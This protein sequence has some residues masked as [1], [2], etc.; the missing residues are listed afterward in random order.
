MGKSPPN[1]NRSTIALAILP[2]TLLVGSWHLTPHSML[3]QAPIDRKAQAD[4]FQQSCQ[5][6]TQRQQYL[7]AVIE[8]Q[9]AVTAFRELGDR[10]R[11]AD[12]LY[13][14]GIVYE[15]VSRSWDA[16]ASYKQ[17]LSIDET[18]SNR[19]GQANALLGLGNTYRSRAQYEWAM[20]YYQQAHSLYVSSNN[21]IGQ[22]H[23]LLGLGAVYQAQSNYQIALNYY[24]DALS[25]FY[26]TNDR[27]GQARA[28]LHLG[29]FY[30]VLSQNQ[31]AIDYYKDALPIFLSLQDRRGEAESLIS[32]GNAY[33]ADHHPQR[34]M[35]YY[36]QALPLFL[37]IDDPQGEAT[38]LLRFGNAHHALGDYQPALEAYKKALRLFR[39]LD[40][41]H[42]EADV[43]NSLGLT[44]R[45]L[46]Q[47]PLAI[48]HFKQAIALYERVGDRNGKAI[49]LGNLGE[50][51][52][53]TGELEAAK[54]Y[55]QQSI[56]LLESIRGN[57]KADRDR[58]S[59]FEIQQ[60]PYVNLQKV[61]V[62][63]EK[64]LPAL[65]I[66][67]RGRARA[68]VELLA[69]K[70]DESSPSEARRLS[71]P[72][73]ATPITIRQIQ[74][75]A[76]E[77]NAHLVEYSII[78]N[79]S[80]YIWVVKPSGD[81]V[82]QQVNLMKLP[83][84]T[85]NPFQTLLAQLRTDELELR[86][87]SRSFETDLTTDA[88]TSASSEFDPQDQSNLNQLHQILIAPIAQHLPK[89][90]KQRIVFIPQRELFFVP[91]PALKDGR[92]TYL[93]ANHTLTTAPSIQ[94]LQLTRQ[95]RRR[96]GGRGNPL[97]VGNP[98][99]PKIGNP[100]EPLSDLP[101]AEAE[102]RAIAQLFGVNFLSGSQATKS[103]VVERMRFAPLIHF[104][105]HGLLDDY[106]GLGIPGAI[107]L[108]PENT[109]G[110]DGLGKINGM[111]TASEILNLSLRAELVVVSACDTGRGRITGDGVI[112]L[113]RAFIAAGA[114]SVVVSLWK[115]PDESTNFLMQQFYQNLHQKMNKAQAL[116]QAMLTTQQKFPDPQ[117]WAAF[118]LIGEAE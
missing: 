52:L 25:R 84:Y 43:L 27:W 8:C 12:A 99:M 26:A 47:Y 85:S 96:E 106:R 79:E 23:A 19:S 90:P 109:P 21:L 55:L 88:Q 68:F 73:P 60:D 70:I 62:A 4:Q 71:I 87:R 111:L 103:R 108:A 11:E 76:R 95:Q 18:L 65:E 77:Q 17:A 3:A 48:D 46:A 75:I 40:N 42:R 83:R 54:N 41:D 80:L 93:T 50:T 39:G 28:L 104:A 56:E 36:K 112:G 63:Q 101:G 2:I 14:V 94:V 105:T 32:L 44:H 30:H 69:H 45:Q 33:A 118:T 9:N 31:R 78:G 57:L 74:Q 113:S 10:A 59:I 102:A 107:A 116:Q 67:E 37:S 35:N 22:S 110:R 98:T 7:A 58:V 1:R 92:G 81:V 15:A 16:I 115:V 82:F 29:Q 61:L 89:D 114:S 24:E 20:D 72:S 117:E 100:P 13:K 49:A 51:L 66:A 86:G 91:F 6:L 5:T 34:A 97:I 53:K 64:P 38:A